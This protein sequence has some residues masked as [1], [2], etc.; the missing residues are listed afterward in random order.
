MLLSVA[1][2]AQLFSQ[3]VPIMVTYSTVGLLISF[4]SG[5]AWSVHGFSSPQR[6]GRAQPLFMAGGDGGD[7]EWMKALLEAGGTSPGE[8]EKQMKMKGLLGNKGVANPKLSANAALI[9]WLEEK[10]DVYLAESSS[11]GEA[12]HPMAISTE[13]RDEITNESSGRGLLARRDVK[14]GD[15]LLKIPME[16]CLTKKSARKTLGKD[17]LPSEINEYLAIASQLIHEKHVL[18]EQSQFKAYVGVLP[19]T[20]EVNPT[21]AWS[22]DDLAF[23]DGSPVIAATRSMQLKLKREHEA[24]FDGEDG[25]WAKFPDRFP[26]EVSEVL[27]NAD[28]SW[29]CDTE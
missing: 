6:A 10:G 2:L 7:A 24:L 9:Q 27:K 17:A 4:A 26:K 22:D 25:L 19:E 21:F 13:T 16:M 1:L 29:L 3:A 28:A 23:L 5:S 20:D 14:E 15:E 11:W 12:P 8:F 18:G